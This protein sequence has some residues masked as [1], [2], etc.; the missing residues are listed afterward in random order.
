MKKY[1][2]LGSVKIHYKPKF[3]KIEVNIDRDLKKLLVEAKKKIRYNLKYTFNFK[4]TYSQR[5]YLYAKSFEDTGWR[6]DKIEDLLYKLECPNSYKNFSIFKINVLN[7]AEEEINETDISINYE[8]I[9]MKSSKKITHIKTLIKSKDKQ[10]I[11][12]KEM[13]INYII[14]TIG[15][16]IDGE[17]DAIKILKALSQIDINKLNY[18]TITSYYDDKVNYVM[19]YYSKHKNYPFIALIIKGIKE[20]WNFSK[21]EQ[22]NIDIKSINTINNKVTPTKTY[23]S[24]NTKGFNNFDGRQYTKEEFKEQ[25]EKLLGWK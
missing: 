7:K 4:S 13:S 21:Q 2:F 17:K 19:D 16:L 12:C 25:E 15:S 1:T 24:N 5:Y 6:I 20:N 23:N 10:I 18:S 3:G 22:F 9:K 14:S 11:Y 8:L